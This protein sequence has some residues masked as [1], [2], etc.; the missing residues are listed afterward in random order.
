MQQI[1]LQRRYQNDPEFAL[2]LRHIPAVAF[3]TTLSV[4]T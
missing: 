4:L 1:G 2:L 3:V